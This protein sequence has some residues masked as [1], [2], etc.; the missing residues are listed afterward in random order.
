MRHLQH[1][2]HHHLGRSAAEPLPPLPPQSGTTLASRRFFPQTPAG[3][4]FRGA[5][6]GLRRPSPTGHA[7]RPRPRPLAWFLPR[8]LCLP[9]AS[10]RPL[11]R[12]AREPGPTAGRGSLSKELAVRG[13]SIRLG[14]PQRPRLGRGPGGGAGGREGRTLA[15]P[16]IAASPWRLRTRGKADRSLQTGLRSCTARAPRW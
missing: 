16:S 7:S 12:A 4:Y 15:R 2:Y 1:R 8:S 6:A 3:P 14:C 13:G 11:L 5:G 10:L 9:R